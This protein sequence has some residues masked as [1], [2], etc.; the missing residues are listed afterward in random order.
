MAAAHLADPH[1]FDADSD[2]DG[3]IRRLCSIKGIGEWTAQYI[4]LRQLRGP[5]TG[6]A[7]DVGLIRAMTV[8]DGHQPSPAE[9]LGRAEA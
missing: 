9:M 7:S 2:L 6:P 8:L 4:A 3:L 5:D 1:L